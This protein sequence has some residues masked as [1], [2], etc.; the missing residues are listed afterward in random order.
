[1]ESRELLGRVARLYYQ[2]GMTHQEIG[3]LLG[4]SRVKVTRL[5]AEAR[6]TGIVEIRIHS[7]SASFG[8]LEAELIGAYGLEQAW[9]APSF[10]DEKRT[11][12]A[13]GLVGAQCLDALV[14]DAG[15]VAVGLSSSVA[16]IVPHLHVEPRPRLGFVPLAGS[17]GGITGGG[18]PHELALRLGT[19]FGA[20]TYHLP[21]PLVASKAEVAEAFQTQSDVRETM[22]M[23][24]GAE[25]LVAGVGGMERRSGILVDSLSRAEREQLAADGAV[26][27]I[28]GRFFDST[29]KG[30]PGSLD[31]RVIGLSLAELRAIPHRVAVSFGTHKIR[32]LHSALCS[33]LV[34][35]VVTDVDTANALTAH[36]TS[37]VHEAS[38][39]NK[40]KSG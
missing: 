7:S 19:A 28:S 38:T 39:G 3:Q 12:D 14:P 17:W 33:G 22:R 15:T 32:A 11:A 37:G 40:R 27:D 20:Q 2:H 25:L 6:R 18:N 36:D 31:D 9:I 8:D 1:M 23:A 5:V 26:G 34:N 10:A 16:T 4:L 13:V 21:A 30:V 24:S 35:M 29:G